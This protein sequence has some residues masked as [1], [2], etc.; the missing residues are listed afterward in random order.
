MKAY[1]ETPEYKAYQ[2]TYQQTPQRKA[3]QKAYNQSPQR[4]AYIKAR[5]QTPEYKVYHKTYLQTPEYKTYNKA[6]QQTPEY[7][8]V[9]KAYQ[10]LPEIKANNKD[11]QLRRKFGITLEEYNI[12]FIS[13]NGCCKICGV[14]QSALTKSLSVDHDHISGKVRGLLCHKCNS[15]LGYA[16]DR[17]QLLKNAIDYLKNSNSNDK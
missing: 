6:R 14:S 11:H 5:Q 4:K 1:R 8:A 17:T 3:Y 16:K 9:G 10:Q 2:K 7:K 15:L 12:M 13:Q